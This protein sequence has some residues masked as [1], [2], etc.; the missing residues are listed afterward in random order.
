MSG[1]SSNAISPI[2]VSVDPTWQTV[3]PIFFVN[4]S[5]CPSSGSGSGFGG[6]KVGHGGGIGHTG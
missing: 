3:S 6:G 2:S 4:S 5:T 1:S